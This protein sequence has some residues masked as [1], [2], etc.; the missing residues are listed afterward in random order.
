LQI[1]GAGLALGLSSVPALFIGFR[2][3]KKLNLPQGHHKAPYDLRPL[4]RYGFLA[5]LFS[6]LIQFFYNFDMLFVKA[7]FSPEDA[8]LYGALLTIGR[9]AYFIGGAVPM[10]M[11][12]VVASFGPAEAM[13]KY[14]TLGKSLLLMVLMMLPVAGVMIFWPSFVINFVVGP[15]YLSMATYLP[16]FTAVI[17]LLTFMTVIGQY[18]LALARRSALYFLATGMILEIVLL[19]LFHDSLYH[20][21]WALFAAF[22][23]NSLGLIILLIVDYL[24]DKKHEK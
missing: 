23:L 8:G 12:P 1:V 16:L 13:R 5:I 17:F 3:I 15:K 7:W 14:K 20:F 22:A 18:Y 4:W 10:V 19:A 2:Q 6:I 21:I 24:K 11:F 9:I